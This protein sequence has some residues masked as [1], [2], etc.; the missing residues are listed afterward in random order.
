MKWAENLYVSDRAAEKKD[1][2]IKKANRVQGMV[3]VYFITL[4]SNQENL[5]DIFHAAHLKQPSFYD[6]DLRVVGIACSMDEA[7]ELTV[8]IISDVYEQTGAFD[9]RSY[10]TFSKE[11]ERKRRRVR[12]TICGM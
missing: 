10:F 12:R 4:A 7:K 6:Q 3:Q 5:L 11:P 8:R 2:I 1:I 9:V